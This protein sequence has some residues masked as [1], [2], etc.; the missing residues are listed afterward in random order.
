MGME[1]PMRM[2]VRMRMWVRIWLRMCSCEYRQA[3]EVFPN[4]CRRQDLTW[5][6]LTLHKLLSANYVYVYVYAA[7]GAPN[8]DF[9]I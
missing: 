2:R 9:Q 3:G 5:L 7:Y 4:R 6:D 1:M 8:F